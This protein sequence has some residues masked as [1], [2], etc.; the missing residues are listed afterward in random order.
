MG[1]LGGKQSMSEKEA[2]HGLSCPRCGGMIDIPE[3]QEVV[4]CPFCELR[5]VVRG[6][7]GIRRYQIPLK[8]D[9][10]AAGK[11]FQS[12]LT[13]SMAISGSVRKE[14]Q[15]T[16]ALVVH[17]PFW[18][19]WGRAAGWIFGQNVIRTQN[20]TRYEPKEI[21]VVEEMTWNGAACEVG[22]FGVSEINLEGRPLEPFD[23]D[24]LHHSGM[25]FEPVGAAGEAMQR[26]QA[27]FDGRIRSAAHVSQL[28]QSFVRIIRPRQG[29][30]F[31]PLWVMRYLYRG[32]A[33]QVVVDGFSG[34]VLY[35]KAPGNVLYRAV[36]L[37]GG[38]ALG[39]FITVQGSYLLGQN[40]QDSPEAALIPLIGGLALMFFSFRKFRYG[41][42]Y[43]Y[44]RRFTTGS[45]PGFSM[46]ASSA[47][48]LSKLFNNL[49]RF[50]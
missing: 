34:E 32:R 47:S 2:L 9:R 25:V 16:E 18:A 31:Y 36:V 8:V 19:V 41:E 39:S 29:L 38:M 10:E 26:A 6:E 50:K 7:N 13:S 27:E 33:F 1:G 43:E 21:R 12:F 49:E 28:T 4:I 20:S 17:L 5:S 45:I 15:L 42:H 11:A 37:V 35:G 44:R 3:G 40:N 14:A 30:V 48:D 24:A 23:G 46:T 22:E